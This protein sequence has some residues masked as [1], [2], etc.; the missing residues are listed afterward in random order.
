MFWLYL[1][2]TKQSLLS[3]Y[4]H[5]YT[6]ILGIIWIYLIMCVFFVMVALG[7]EFLERRCGLDALA[8]EGYDKDQG[9]GESFDS[10]TD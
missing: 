10:G 2:L 5:S 4:G 3:H 7:S 8:Q 9:Q 1:E 6:L